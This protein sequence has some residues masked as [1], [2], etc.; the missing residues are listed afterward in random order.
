MF[1]PIDIPLYTLLVKKR[2][3]KRYFKEEEIEAVRLV[4]R[5]KSCLSA[6][7]ALVMKHYLHTTLPKWKEMNRIEKVFGIFAFVAS[8]E[9]Y[10]T[11]NV[12]FSYD[13]VA[14]SYASPKKLISYI[15]DRLR[16]NFKDAFGCPP[17]FIITFE[18]DRKRVGKDRVFHI[19]GIIETEG[20]NLPELKRIV[21][22]T[23]FGRGYF[24]LEMNPFILKKRKIFCPFGWL[25]YM[26]KKGARAYDDMYI[27]REIMRDFR[28]FYGSLGIDGKAISKR[29]EDRQESTPSLLR[30]EVTK[31][32][33]A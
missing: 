24:S 9:R 26:T 8:P 6:P 17:K 23:A 1:T 30:L 12:R 16:Q 28:S 31:N 21:K 5:I 14:H 10:M 25:L 2:K 33:P 3:R 27:S 22:I 19:H 4:Q 7:S 13:F 20:F 32:P 18:L 29:E 15:S 11:F